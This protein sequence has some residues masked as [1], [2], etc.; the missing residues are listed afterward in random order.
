MVAQHRVISL[1]SSVPYILFAIR[2]TEVEFGLFRG[3]Y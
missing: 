1:I 2:F 3:C